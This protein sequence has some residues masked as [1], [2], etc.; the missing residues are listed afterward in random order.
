M[1]N[2]NR[3]LEVP[4]ANCNSTSTSQA[5]QSP[6]TKDKNSNS[7]D[8]S[9]VGWTTIDVFHGEK[10]A[11][12]KNNSPN[13][14]YSQC[15]QDKVVMAL[16][17]NKRNG[18]FLDLAAND[19]LKF[20][21]TYVLERKLDWRGLCIEP[22]PQYWFG[23]TRYRT[24]QLVAAVAGQHKM[25]KIQFSYSRGK[26]G[27]MVKEGMD[28]AEE[29]EAFPAYTVPLQ[30]VLERFDAPVNIDYL[31][32]DIEGAETYVMKH[33]PFVKYQIKV[34]TVER[35]DDELQELFRSHGYQLMATIGKFGETVWIHKDSMGSLDLTVLQPENLAKLVKG[36]VS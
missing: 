32:L 22:N 17:K 11:P 10:Q 16:F 7:N 21:N 35:P 25:E 8:T 26:F 36:R 9:N 30:E 20:S 13:R 4:K 29:K 19:A 5:T 31:S 1:V 33:F 3:R 6:L 27:G 34:M 28:N 14:S 23:F 15:K 2:D 12:I 18:F 24:C